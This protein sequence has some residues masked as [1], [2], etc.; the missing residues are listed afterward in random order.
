MIT[1]LTSFLECSHTT[2]IQYTKINVKFTEPLEPS[3]KESNKNIYKLPGDGIPAVQQWDQQHLCNTGMQVQSLA[4]H[5]GLRIQCCC[6]SWGSSQLRLR[7]DLWPRNS[8]CCGVARKIN[9]NDKQKFFHVHTA[10]FN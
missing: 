4:Q 5:S 3:W 6:R 8:I 1:F 2:V 7:S 9:K 10:I